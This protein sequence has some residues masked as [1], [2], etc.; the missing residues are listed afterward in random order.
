MSP[1]PVL[2]TAIHL[3]GLDEGLWIVHAVYIFRNQ[4]VSN[5]NVLSDHF[6]LSIIGCIVIRVST[7]TFHFC[8]LTIAFSICMYEMSFYL[9]VSQF[10]H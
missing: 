9:S 4:F 3:L 6:T 7:I 1:N 8:S 10:V 5:C 2:A